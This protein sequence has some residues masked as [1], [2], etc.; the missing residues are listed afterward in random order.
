MNSVGDLARLYCFGEGTTFFANSL[1]TNFLDSSF[2]L[3]NGGLEI[4]PCAD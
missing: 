2:N 3:I 4:R 1:T